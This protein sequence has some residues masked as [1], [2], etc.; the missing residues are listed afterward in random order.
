MA[1]RAVGAQGRG[2]PPAPVGAVAPE[3][4]QHAVGLGAADGGPGQGGPEGDGGDPERGRGRRAALLEQPAEVGGQRGIGRRR[5]AAPGV[6]LTQRT[7]IGRATRPT[8]REDSGSRSDGYRIVSISRNSASQ[9]WVFPKASPSG[10][11]SAARLLRASL[12][13]LLLCSAFFTATQLGR[14]GVSR[15][16]RTEN[17]AGDQ[18]EQQD[19]W[20]VDE[21]TGRHGLRS[22]GAHG[23]CGE[24]PGGRGER[25]GRGAGG[26]RGEGVRG[27]AVIRIMPHN[28][29]YR[30]SFRLMFH[31]FPEE[32]IDPER[33]QR[34]GGRVQHRPP[35]G[36]KNR[37]FWGGGAQGFS[38]LSGRLPTAGTS[39]SGTPSAEC[40]RRVAAYF[41]K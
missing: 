8:I 5:G 21:V 20:D 38:G 4:G 3:A 29:N 14:I 13:R 32:T 24:A 34:R 11:A 18:P 10:S 28:Y 15:R 35:P 6:E 22:V 30:S 26:S 37:R 39:V 1:A 16:A 12:P 2:L 19:G 40:I 41:A 9:R 7:A 17:P 31:P 27:P 36:A 23:V 25:P 33:P